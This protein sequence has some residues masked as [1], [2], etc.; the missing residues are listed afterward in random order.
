[1]TLGTTA[2]PSTITFALNPLAKRKVVKASLKCLLSLVLVFLGREKYD[3]CLLGA[4][5]ACQGRNV[6]TLIFLPALFATVGFGRAAT[7]DR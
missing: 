5:D 1:M 4:T 2:Q 3:K 6:E 7:T